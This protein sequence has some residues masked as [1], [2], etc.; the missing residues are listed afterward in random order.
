[1]AQQFKDLA[2]SLLWVWLLLWC[3][4]DPWPK[5]FYMLQVRPGSNKNNNT[6]LYKYTVFY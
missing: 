1:M 5:N 6:P 4:F 2:L 3:G